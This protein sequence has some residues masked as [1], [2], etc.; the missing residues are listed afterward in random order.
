MAPKKQ[1]LS[2]GGSSSSLPHWDHTRFISREASEKYY[3]IIASES[4]VPE[5][6]LR[7]DARLDGEMF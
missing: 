2:I 7:P 5:R 6:G 4:L 1:K 3:T